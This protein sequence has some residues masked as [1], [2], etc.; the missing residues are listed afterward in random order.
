VLQLNVDACALDRRRALIALRLEEL[1]ARALPLDPIRFYGFLH[2]Q[3]V[4]FDHDW[5]K[6]NFN[7]ETEKELY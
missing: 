4:A 2:P 7:Y 6:E 1:E 5:K 3:L